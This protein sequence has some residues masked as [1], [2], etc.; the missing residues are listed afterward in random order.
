MSQTVFGE[1]QPSISEGTHAPLELAEASL[2]CPFLHAEYDEDR[3]SADLF[4]DSAYRDSSIGAYLSCWAGHVVESD[5]RTRGTSGGVGTWIGAELLRAGLIDA[6]VHVKQ[7]PR[8]GPN[9]PFASYAISRSIAEIR[10][11]AGTRYHAT[12]MADV[13][14]EIS[15]V[16]A[17]YL[18]IGVP[19]YCKAVRRLQLIDPVIRDRVRFVF[20]LVCGHMKSLNW[21]LSLAWAAGVAPADA[22]SF[23]YRTKAPG[24]SARDYVFEVT[25]RA[26]GDT[27]RRAAKDCV[28][29]RFNAGALMLPACDY[30]DDVVGETADLTVGDA[31][32]PQFDTDPQGTNLLVVRSA[33]IEAVLRSATARGALHLTPVSAAEAAASQRGGLRHRREGLSYRLAQAALHGRW[34]PVK[35]V[36]AGS[37][38]I[39]W[40]RRCIYD[41]RA[42]I[43]AESR[44]AFV[45]AL[46]AGDY[47]AYVR[48]MRGLTRMLRRYEVASSCVT[49][50]RLTLKRGYLRCLH[51]LRA[52]FSRS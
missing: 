20:S 15:Q 40:L 47:T 17:R 44:E 45:A 37:F 4:D 3:L 33:A 6:V 38:R 30:C 25:D 52:F 28:G 48:R 12:H 49:I 43:T 24:I 9:D 22:A 35:R 46:A 51:R 8:S 41:L 16:D 10:E 21:T 13:L 26:T 14:R 18:F 2:A 34:T 32:L 42:R 39:S 7:I 23:R 50:G 5:W 1:Y 27:H 31:W 29:G 36:V 11:A 19:C